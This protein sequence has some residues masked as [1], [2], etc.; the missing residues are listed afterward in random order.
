MVKQQVGGEGQK[1]RT[2]GWEGFPD[3]AESTA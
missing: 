3:R 1:V 2:E